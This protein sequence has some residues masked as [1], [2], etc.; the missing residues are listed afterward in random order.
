MCDTHSDSQGQPRFAIEIRME[1]WNA[2]E[3]FASGRMAFG[4]TSS[5][6]DPRWRAICLPRR[7]IDVIDDPSAQEP[8]PSS[9]CIEQRSQTT[10][11]ALNARKTIASHIEIA[12]PSYRDCLNFASQPA[13]TSIDFCLMIR[14]LP[15]AEAAAS[16]KRDRVLFASSG[17]EWPALDN[18]RQ[19]SHH[20]DL[21]F[22]IWDSWAHAYSESLTSSQ[23][24]A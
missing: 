1:N 14:E 17:G 18:P 8:K 3:S 15:S 5:P 20:L 9:N 10:I 2:Q 6:D 21:R 4:E 24:T 11:S 12:F 22:L 16:P 19:I 23:L 7:S 13:R